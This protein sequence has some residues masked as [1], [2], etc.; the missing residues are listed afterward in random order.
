MM[1]RI[2]VPTLAFAVALGSAMPVAAQQT[3]TRL[4]GESA[5]QMA[6]RLGRCSDSEI[7]SAEFLEDGSALRL[8]VTCASSSAGINTAAGAGG[9]GTGGAIA[10]GLGIAAVLGVAAASSSSSSTN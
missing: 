9:L 2:T 6:E 10:A 1:K 4:E 7:A 5:M 3:V 8:R